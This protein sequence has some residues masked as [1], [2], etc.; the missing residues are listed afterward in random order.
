VAKT[1]DETPMDCSPARDLSR[2]HSLAGRCFAEVDLERHV[3]EPRH[4]PD[5]GEVPWDGVAKLLRDLGIELI[6]FS[7]SAE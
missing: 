1:R 4:S 2:W 7:W 5:M 6:L 3:K